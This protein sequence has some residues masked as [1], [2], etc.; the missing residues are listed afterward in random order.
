MTQ[1][2]CNE[3]Y[4]FWF[5]PSL[6]R[7]IEKFAPQK[8][9]YRIWIWQKFSFL[10]AKSP[11]WFRISS[12]YSMYTSDGSICHDSFAVACTSQLLSS[13]GPKNHILF[14]CTTFLQ[15]L[16]SICCSVKLFLLLYS[17]Y[18]YKLIAISLDCCCLY[19]A[20][21]ALLHIVSC[22]VCCCF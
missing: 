17:S 15:L 22:F 5:Q 2:S 10:G 18:D 1:Q 13:S 21:A 19:A 4:A 8:P 6:D 14:Q 20:A 11:S 9:S 3:K 16:S 12:S 7:A